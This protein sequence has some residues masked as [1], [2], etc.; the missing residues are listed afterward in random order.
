MENQASDQL[1]GAMPTS[2]IRD[3]P[4]YWD[5]AHPV[6]EVLRARRASGSLPGQRTDNAKVA[7]AVEGGGRPGRHLADAQAGH[8]RLP[9]R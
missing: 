1:R 4:E 7:L 3:L 2:D 5:P 8:R 6:L 9:H